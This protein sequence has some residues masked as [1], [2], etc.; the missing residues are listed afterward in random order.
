K[1]YSVEITLPHRGFAQVVVRVG[2]SCGRAIRQR[3]Y[4]SGIM[5][6]RPCPD[7]WGD[8]GKGR[9]KRRGFWYTGKHSGT[10][11]L[12]HEWADCK[13]SH[14]LILSAVMKS[15][16]LHGMGPGSRAPYTCSARP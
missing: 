5:A 13:N 7:N 16:A 2:F 1:G 11:S 3:Y 6:N 15:F 4:A 9:S 10:R 14:W 8:R 12:R